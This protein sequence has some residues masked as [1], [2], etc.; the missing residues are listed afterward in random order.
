MFQEKNLHVH[1]HVLQILQYVPKKVLTQDQINT[2]LLEI[3]KLEVLHNFE[4]AILSI[5]QTL[6]S[7]YYQEFFDHGM[8]LNLMSHSKLDSGKKALATFITELFNKSKSSFL[9]ALE[10]IVEYDNASI[11]NSLAQHLPSRIS[12]EFQQ[13]FLKTILENPSVEKK[14]KHGRAFITFA[15]DSKNLASSLIDLFDSFENSTKEEDQ[16]EGI[17]ITLKFLVAEPSWE[18]SIRNQPIFFKM[19]D[20][21][22][23]RRETS[24]KASQLFE[25]FFRSP[26]AV[27]CYNSLV[28][29][30]KAMQK[31][32][33]RLKK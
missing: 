2:M 20:F 9:A 13:V 11:F 26:A 15:I 31:E 28:N 8:T 7:D 14:T 4:E 5:I 16:E 6:C 27:Y 29:E 30:M 10:S 25:S 24:Q 23:S 22:K 12:K 18:L 33:E 19:I 17:L 32:I 21:I 1:L 3:E